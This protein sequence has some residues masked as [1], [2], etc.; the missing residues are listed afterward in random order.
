MIRVFRYFEID[1]RLTES[2]GVSNVGSI[3]A[4]R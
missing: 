2:L 1:T 3:G 4:E